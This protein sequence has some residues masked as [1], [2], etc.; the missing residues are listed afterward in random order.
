MNF[1]RLALVVLAFI[2]PAAVAQSQLGLYGAVTVE[3]VGGIQCLTTVCGSPDGT[4]NPVGG[5]GGVY[6]DF[7]SYGRVRLGVDV[8]GGATIQSKNAAQY[9]TGPKPRIYSALGGIR[10]SF[11]TRFDALRPYVQGSV[12][13]A[14]SNFQT[15]AGASA[16]DYPVGV[17]Y[18]AYAGADLR[19]LPYLD[20]RVVELGIGAIQLQGTAYRTESISTGVVFHFA[21]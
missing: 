3:H 2:A 17:Q 6:Y 19:L 16:L 1:S 7:K 4:I 10:A 20:F 14:R 21:H 12:G 11:P 13:M 5:F 18:R 8:R 9:F 15:S